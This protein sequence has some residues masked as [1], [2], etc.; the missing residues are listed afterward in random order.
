MTPAEAAPKLADRPALAVLLLTAGVVAWQS[1]FPWLFGYDGFFHLALARRMVEQGLDPTMDWMAFSIFGAQGE[2]FVDHHFG[3][4]VALMPFVAVLPGVI[5][6]KVAA[7]LFAALALAVMY[8]WLRREQVPQP[9]LVT[10]APMALSWA[11]VFR[12]GMVRA[13][14]L[15]IV[16]LV[17]T[18]Y[19]AR[20][21]RTFALAAVCVVYALFYQLSVLAIPIALGAW[22]AE[23]LFGQA[24]DQ[25]RHPGPWTVV[26]AAV[27]VAVGLTVHPDFPHTWPYLLRHAGIGA[28]RSTIPIGTEWAATSWRD[29]WMQGY[30]LIVLVALVSPFALRAARARGRLRPGT[31]LLLAGAACGVVLA[32]RNMR[33]VELSM[34]LS[35]MALGLL[36]RDSGWRPG[37]AGLIA[38]WLVVATL[39][40]VTAWRATHTGDLDPH[41]FAGA[42]DWLE[43]N[44]EPGELLYNVRWAEWS[45][46]VFHAPDY[47]FVVGLT[48]H[49]LWMHDEE[50][51]KHF[52]LVESGYYTNP[53]DVV[54]E[55]FGARYLVI[56]AAEGEDLARLGEDP[57]L[58]LAFRDDG[59]VVYRIPPPDGATD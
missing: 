48:P 17:A 21:G 45:E 58:E 24:P 54:W 56:G 10:L 15:S 51:F 38:A 1:S 31:P 3:F 12:M 27:G 59:A 19:L 13:M 6:G 25:Q 43:E 14:S 9:L 41:R 46:W 7:S 55:Q 53:G 57:R 5:A 4:H 30:G 28:T 44:V 33:W 39:V 37:R 42:A 32:L 34:P 47:R 50:R 18:I 35:A 20:A 26:G 36:W 22:L 8:L 49:N 52:M 2:A 40:P 16:L 23:R 29:G 11:F